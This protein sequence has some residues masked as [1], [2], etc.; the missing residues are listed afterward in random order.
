MKKDV[1]ETNPLKED[2]L[3]KD[4]KII[5]SNLSSQLALFPDLPK[6]SYSN[7]N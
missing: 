7:V 2:S 1:L 5:K 3:T 4:Q 6:T